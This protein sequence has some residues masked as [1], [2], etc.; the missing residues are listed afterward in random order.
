MSTTLD[1]NET[2]H[3]LRRHR[4]TIHRQ[5]G[6]L[7]RRLRGA[8]LLDGF[9][10]LVVVLAV[11]ALLSLSFDWLVR[12]EQTTRIALVVLAGIGIVWL[13]VRRLIWPVSIH[14]DDLDLAELI[15]RRAPGVGEKMANILQ[16][17]QLA[18]PPLQASPGMVAATVESQAA[19]VAKFDCDRAFD[20]RRRRITVGGL[21]GV[22]ALAAVCIAVWPG[23]TSLWAKRWFLASDVRWPQRTYVSVVGLG[24]D[25][26]L[27]APRGESFVVEVDS[28]P[29]FVQT[30]RGWLLSGR[31][32]PLLVDSDVRP[33]SKVPE[34]VRLRTTSA[35]GKRKQAL[36]AA[37]DK[38]RFRYELPP[39]VEPLN[40]YLTADDDW[41]GPISIEPVDRPTVDGLM[42]KARQP[43]SDME[44]S[45]QVG[46]S[47]SELLFLP[48]TQL[49]FEL[50]SD[51]D[52][53]EA[54]AV[55]AHG[56][57]WSLERTGNRTFQTSWEMKEAVT[58][59][60]RLTSA[61]TGLES[62]PYFMTIGLLDDRKPRVSM[63]SKG[64]R[65]RVTARARIP[66]TLRA[67][68][69]FGIE[70]LSTELEKT[71]LEGDKT[72]TTSHAK[73]IETTSP[74]DAVEKGAE[75]GD[76][77]WEHLVIVSLSDYEAAPGNSL[78]LRGAAVDRCVLGKQTGYSRWL[79]FEVVTDEELFFEILMRQRAQRARFEAALRMMKEHTEPLQRMPSREEVAAM[80]RTQ[81]VVKRQV[82][83]IAN[84]LESS[85]EELAINDLSDPKSRQVLATDVIAPLRELHDDSITR[86]RAPLQALA[87]EDPVT[88]ASRNDA[89]QV[90]EEVIRRM[91]KI[92]D[93]MAEWES[94]VDVV[95]QL[96]HVMEL[97]EKTLKRTEEIQ[98]ERE[99][100]LFDE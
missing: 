2:M 34:V 36:F 28:Q 52:L 93:R 17:P 18:E 100:S 94:F 85:L 67:V 11:L 39:I 1:T 74:D 60:L 71:V 14:L 65:R 27:L 68:D 56:R 61:E 12:L 83:Q 24:D 41:L 86:F 57:A 8:L 80:L 62:K 90:H 44:R 35:S 40:L 87:A 15:N 13:A 4:E 66:V 19:D 10:L 89:Q 46:E 58:L 33:T 23:V 84:Q 45:Y 95:N 30:D 53:A 72:K 43:G 50:T 25:G 73:P 20:E 96:R 92:L 48:T 47:D 76:T 51:Q 69:D 63:R 38:G 91:Q 16:L 9:F 75:E 22:L 59:E 88:E 37:L 78:R 6:R 7:R 98:Q 29:Q 99:E 3:R 49:K 64:V 81:Q 77:E 5:L 26:R 79:P 55:D 82:W 31:G 42:V 32:R 21:I 70:S 54:G 97:Q